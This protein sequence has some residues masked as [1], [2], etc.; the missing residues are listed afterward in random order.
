[1]L[2]IKKLSKAKKS[3][4]KKNKFFNKSKT[5]LKFYVHTHHLKKIL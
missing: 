3:E 2:T 5:L 1:M 4:R